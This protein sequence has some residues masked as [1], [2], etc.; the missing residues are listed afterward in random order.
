M[1]TISTN[2]LNRLTLAS[3]D[4][5]WIVLAVLDEIMYSAVKLSFE[6]SEVI[7]MAVVLLEVLRQG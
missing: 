3:L 4:V 1:L 2:L 7:I 5:E 6:A